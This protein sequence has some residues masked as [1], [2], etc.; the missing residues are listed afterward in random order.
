MKAR[1]STALRF[2][3]P[4][5]SLPSTLSLVF[6]EGSSAECDATA[7]KVTARERGFKCVTRLLGGVLKTSRDFLPALLAR[8][9]ANL[10]QAGIPRGESRA[11]R[12]VRSLQVKEVRFTFTTPE[13]MKSPV[14]SDW[15][16]I[17][18]TRCTRGE[19]CPPS[20]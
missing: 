17:F 3:V 7:F 16:R 13:N 14:P 12:N 4:P 5:T 18:M 8:E 19:I 11:F 6:R 1:F 9:D 2:N 15:P 10:R 20:L